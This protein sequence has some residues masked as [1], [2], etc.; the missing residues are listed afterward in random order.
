[1][2]TRA[3][4]YAISEVLRR[5][6]VWSVWL[7]EILCE[8][9][10]TAWIFFF[11]PALQD[12]SGVVHEF[13][14]RTLIGIALFVLI[15]FTMTGYLVTTALASVFLRSR[16]W[17]LYPIASAALYL[18]HSEAFFVAVGNKMFDKS[19]ARIQVLGACITFACTFAG[20]RVLSRRGI[21]W[22]RAA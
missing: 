16:A 14:V 22:P 9:L 7:L 3:Q 8:A 18:I 4:D 21:K 12:F 1:M 19:N 11:I 6:R 13:R 2:A 17:F 10:G 20:S 15:E 5:L